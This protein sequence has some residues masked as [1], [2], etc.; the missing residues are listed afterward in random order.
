MKYVGARYMPKFMG[1]HDNTTAYEALSVVDNGMGTSYVSNKPVPVGVAL[2]NTE[3]W[4]VYGASSGAILDLET[5]MTAA[6]NDISSIDDTINMLGNAINVKTPPSTTGLTGV[7][8]DGVVDDTIALDAII[9]Y[10][11]G[12][13]MSVFFP[14]GTYKISSITIKFTAAHKTLNM[15]GVGKESIIL[16][17]GLGIIYINESEVSVPNYCKV[18]NLHFRGTSTTGIRLLQFINIFNG[19]IQN[20]L[21][22][23]ADIGLVLGSNI[24]GNIINCRFNGCGW[25]NV[26]M[27]GVNE[28]A[29]CLYAGN[30]AVNFIGCVSYGAGRDGFEC[31]GN[32]GCNFYG[33]TS[34]NNA[35]CGIR[36]TKSGSFNGRGNLV[37][38]CWFE[39][40][41]SGHVAI[42]G[43][44]SAPDCNETVSDCGF[45]ASDAQSAACVS[46]TSTNAAVL[47]IGCHF[48]RLSGTALSV[49]SSD[50][51]RSIHNRFNYTP[52]YSEIASEHSDTTHCR[53]NDD[54]TYIQNTRDFTEITKLS[55]GAYRLRLNHWINSISI[56]AEGSR[57]LATGKPFNQDNGTCIIDVNIRDIDTWATIDSPFSIIA[58]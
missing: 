15:F 55:T 1:L 40:N 29:R 34:E 21:F 52:V 41:P 12:N 53:V 9:Q 58:M 8:G 33:C 44:A 19:L 3:Y 13:D 45:V 11:L 38:G 20:C 25:D 23:N 42:D 5:R 47:V 16:S 24:W 39:F 18:E 32:S 14:A 54:G 31:I 46:V 6:E 2:S 35:A 57:Y 4:T 36:I 49:S 51:I 28:D 26:Y 56:T 17:N 43:S 10:A 50:N 37:S 48:R 30:N 22:E 7:V 27:C